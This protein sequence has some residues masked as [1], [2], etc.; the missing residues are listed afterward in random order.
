[1]PHPWVAILINVENFLEELRLSAS[2]R[3]SLRS[4]LQELAFSRVYLEALRLRLI[5]RYLIDFH[6]SQDQIQMIRSYLEIASQKVQGN[7]HS[8][9]YQFDKTRLYSRCSCE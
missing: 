4:F 7:P 3:H 9:G 8:G 6:D 5:F 2:T 1:M